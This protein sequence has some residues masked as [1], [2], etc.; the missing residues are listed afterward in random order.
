MQE[1]D[2]IRGPHLQ[3]G[4]SLG[5]LV[6]DADVAPRQMRRRASSQGIHAARARR[7]VRPGRGDRR[8]RR[9]GPRG[10]LA[11]SGHVPRATSTVKTSTATP[12][13]PLMLAAR[14]SM[15]L[16]A[17]APATDENRPGRSGAAT[18]TWGGR[19]DTDGSPVARTSAIS[20]R[21]D[22]TMWSGAGGRV[23][24]GARGLCV[25]QGRRRGPPSRL[26]RPRDRSPCCQPP[27]ARP[28]NGG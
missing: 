17:R 20:S 1:A 25:R 18:M 24:L 2:F 13:S 22:S 27:S 3:D 11:V 26:P 4:G 23:H 9:P 28:I 15:P 5:G 14:T 8:A 12:S 10:N 21:F 7:A 19:S 16:R 6:V